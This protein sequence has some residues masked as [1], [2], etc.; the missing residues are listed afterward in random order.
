MSKQQEFLDNLKNPTKAHL[1]QAV[2]EFQEAHNSEIYS[3]IVYGNYKDEYTI[4]ITSK[5]RVS[6]RDP[7]EELIELI[8][9]Y[10]KKPW[11]NIRIHPDQVD[12]RFVRTY[13]VMEAS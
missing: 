9:K 3:A 10:L 4:E 2:T 12:G 5:N 1:K 13:Y 8:K 7:E 6:W 11:I